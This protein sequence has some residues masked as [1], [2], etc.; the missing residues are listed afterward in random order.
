MSV[1]IVMFLLWGMTAIVTELMMQNKVAKK[2]L[3]RKMILTIA[4]G[5]L[6]LVMAL[7]NVTVGTDTLT[8]KYEYENAYYYLQT[9]Q[10][11]SELGYTYFNYIINKLGF[12]F[13]SYLAIISV[14][15]ISAVSILIYRYSKNI[16]LSYY[17]HVTIGLFAMTMTGL[18]QTIAV[19]LTIF[20]F[21]L[22][23]KNKKLA[24]FILVGLAY[25]F[26][27]SA[28][29]FL[30]VFILRKARINKKTGLIIYGISCFLF[31]ANEWIASIILSFAP[32]KYLRYI[33]MSEAPNVNPLVIIVAMAIP[34]AC[35]IF[36]PKEEDKSNEEYNRAMSIILIISCINFVI[37]FFA[38]K[39]NMLERMSLYFMVYNVI[40]IPNIVERIKD[41]ETRMIAKVA[42]VILPLLQFIISTP[43]TSLGID[44]Y[45]FF[46]Q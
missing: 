17:L 31:V 37:Y 18:R 30:V 39:I 26:H 7:R 21:V 20:A 44:K 1:Y 42:C 8:Y 38:L 3:S 28:I 11:P 46:W 13:Q 4:S 9:M 14:F 29:I 25:V 12:S 10:R 15:V 43:G 22:L 41:K 45:K 23:I 33:Q 19:A 2:K 27:N 34:L 40:L 32:A 5:T 24:F 6:F 16:L 36:W 35:L